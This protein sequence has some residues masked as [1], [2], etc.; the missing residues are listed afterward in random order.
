[1]KNLIDFLESEH[2]D[3]MEEFKRQATANYWQAGVAYNPI[4]GGFG[5]A[6]ASNKRMIIKHARV[7][8]GKCFLHLEDERPTK[9]HNG[10]EVDIAEAHKKLKRADENKDT[11]YEFNM[12]NLGDTRYLTVNDVE[13]VVR[14]ITWRE[15]K[16][17]R[18][19]CRIWINEKNPTQIYNTGF[20]TYSPYYEI[21]SHFG[22]KLNLKHVKSWDS[23]GRENYDIKLGISM[24]DIKSR[25]FGDPNVKVPPIVPTEELFED[26]NKYFKK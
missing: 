7:S 16:T 17:E 21:Y 19:C 9:G 14:L 15:Y 24:R 5:T 22:S 25:I 20:T 1:M 18:L 23:V 26:F 8:K 12:P 13:Y 2:S 10:Y 4:T 6:R 11:I 3:I